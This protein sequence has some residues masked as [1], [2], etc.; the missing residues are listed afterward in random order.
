M[1]TPIKIRSELKSEM[2]QQDD[3]G[4][5]REQG[6]PSSQ[7]SGTGSSIKP[8]L[9][10]KWPLRFYPPIFN[11][12]TILWTCKYVLA[13]FYQHHI[14]KSPYV[15]LSNILFATGLLSQ[16]QLHQCPVGQLY[17]FPPPRAWTRGWVLG[18]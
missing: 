13:G 14:S 18:D 17:L 1:R 4:S 6:K 8:S 7:R 15:V 16:S 9:Y 2:S 3:T 10:R 11:A 5:G 12:C